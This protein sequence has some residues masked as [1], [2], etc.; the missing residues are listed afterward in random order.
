MIQTDPKSSF[1]WIAAARVEELDGKLQAARSILAQGLQKAEDSED[2]WIELARLETPDK[3]RQI[4][5]KAVQTLPTSIKIWLSAVSKENDNKIK[6]KLLKRA[7][8]Y[9]PNSIEIWKELIG[10][11]SEDE[12]LILLYKAVEC[13]PKN[14]SLWLALAKL[15]S[16]DN[17][18]AILNKARQ[19][20][21]QEPTI[22]I[23]AAKL[24]ESA[25]RDKALITMVLSKGIKVLQKNDVKINKD[26]W[27]NE[28]EIA[29]KCNN[30]LTCHAIVR[31]IL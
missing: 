3:A 10:L 23:N 14:L 13:I 29:E 1:G 9:I 12:A 6:I 15:E 2:I 16:Y 17:A 20:L 7:L 4:L 28:A 25:G 22:W 30:V 18:K 8:E 11:S 27:L 19:A 21:P 5:A 24:E 31:A 26:D